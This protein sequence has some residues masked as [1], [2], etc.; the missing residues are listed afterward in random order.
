MSD[1]TLLRQ[2]LQATDRKLHQMRLSSYL[3]GA[4]TFKRSKSAYAQTPHGSHALI[5]QPH[6]GKAIRYL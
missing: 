1:I 6:P 5:V 3:P 2:Q 4:L